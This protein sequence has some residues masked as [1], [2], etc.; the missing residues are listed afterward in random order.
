MY[1][2]NC[3]SYLKRGS[4]Y[5]N[6]NKSGVTIFPR[7][8]RNFGDFNIHRECGRFGFNA[9]LIAGNIFHEPKIVPASSV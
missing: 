2:F 6:E 5:P 4:M 9:K 7:L 1:Y 3:H 8:L